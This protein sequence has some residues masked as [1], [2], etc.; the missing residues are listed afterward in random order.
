MDAVS[1]IFLN[2][3]STDMTVMEQYFPFAEKAFSVMQYTA[4]AVLFLITV[5]ELFKVFGGPIAEAEPPFQLLARASVFAFLIGN[6]RPLFQLA[7]DVATAPYTALMEIDLS[8]EDFTFA[9]IQQT[10]TNGLATL[11]I[12]STVVGEILMLILLISLGWNYFKLLLQTVERYVVV[13]VLCYTSPL[14]YCMGGAKATGSVFKSWCRMVGSQLLMLVMN[15]WFLRGFDSSVGHFIANGGA[16]SNGKGS[17]FL[18]LFYALA[19]LKVAQRFDS[20]LGSIGLNVAQTGGSMGME[21]LMAA[22]VITELGGGGAKSA[23]SVFQSPTA[24]GAG[25]VAG[26][27]SASAAGGIQSAAANIANRFKAN[28]YVRDAVV[29]G[30][31]RM[32]AVG[33]LGFA[34]RAFGGVA[35]QNGASLTGSSISSVASKHPKVSGSIGGDIANRSLSNYLPQ[36]GGHELTNTQITGGHISTTATN[37]N[38]QSSDVELFHAAQYEAPSSCPYSMV[39][40]S[41]GSMWYQTASG[42]GRGDFF[43]TPEL[44]GTAE[45]A[46]QVSSLFPTAESG[47]ILR[48][49]GEGML[50]ATTAAGDSMW[51]SSAFFDEPEAPHTTLSDSGG[52][53]WYAMQPRG[54]APAFDP[55]TDS[56][57]VSYNKAEFRSFMPGFASEISSVDGSQR[58]DGRLEVHHPDGSGTAFYDSAVYHAPRGS[59]SV[60]EDKNGHQWY[61]VQGTPSVEHRPVYENGKPVYDNGKL[62]TESVASIRYST[63][64]QQF[65]VPRQLAD[66]SIK[67]PRRKP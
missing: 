41:D 48:T 37:E 10:I 46:D 2:T 44:S 42:D 63:T 7:L 64:P 49:A 6:A 8:A 26:A 58:M 1:G 57:A 3:L 32:G 47:T 55:G 51:F 18:W 24:K 43:A 13:G 15:V 19:F 31:Q 17:V 29:E 59:S 9:G 14:A 34:A 33:G 65:T 50:A 23:G 52:T 38:G 30:G 22:R 40:A 5:W 35:A 45:E 16:L 4:W 36:F 20:Y 60:Y 27:A 39:T 11:V 66:T 53:S 67:A 54:S 25:A 61:A 62:K 56:G 28:S 12:S 21:M